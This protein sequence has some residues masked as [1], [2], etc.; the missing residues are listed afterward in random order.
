MPRAGSS[1][2]SP[3]F[4]ATARLSTPSPA[5]TALA[6]RIR[7]Q[8]RSVVLFD[9][10]EKADDAAFDLLL[11]VLGEGRLT[12]AFGRLVDFRMSLIV[13]TTNLGAADPRPAGFSS[14]PAAP[15]DPSG[16]IKNFFRPELLGRLDAVIAFRPLPPPAL[17][18]IVDLALGKLR[19]RPGFVA[20]SLRL[21]LS[22]RARARHAGLGP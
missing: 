8:P 15:A 13:M 4:A 14:D 10:S 11:G 2:C 18:A 6:D 20:R 1:S 22:P 16:A 21:E 5:G 12:D 3:R 19:A 9:E 17:A 7:R